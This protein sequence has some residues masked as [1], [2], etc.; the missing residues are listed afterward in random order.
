MKSTP[1]VVLDE[2]MS[3]YKGYS[4]V[5][6][7]STQPFHLEKYRKL[8]P[9]FVYDHEDLRIREPLIEHVGGLPVVATAI[10]P[11][12]GEADVDLGDALKM[13][14]IHD[15]GELATG[16][17]ITFTKQSAQADEEQTR[18]LEMLHPS[19]HK[20]YM[21]METQSTDTGK[22]AKAVDKMT[23][24]IV[25]LMTPA[26]I[27]IERYGKH[28]KKSPEEIVPLIKEHKHPYMTWNDFIKD[29][30]LLILTK[31]EEKI[32]THAD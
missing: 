32:N 11:H 22:F 27:T 19:Y 6:R 23:P 30:H 16:D 18:A 1:Q 15:I 7:A 29:L 17:E 13:L 4:R 31:L 21:D 3:L 26:E 9:S 10:Y 14:A 25:D 2:I 12:I 8:E 20:M 24:D 5:H 28:L